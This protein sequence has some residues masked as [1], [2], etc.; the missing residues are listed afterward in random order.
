MF[1][2]HTSD[3]KRHFMKDDEVP[4]STAEPFEMQDIWQ[5]I[6]SKIFQ[7]HNKKES[8]EASSDV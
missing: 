2:F 3:L 1:G 5:T 6:V 8:S 4:L 7:Q